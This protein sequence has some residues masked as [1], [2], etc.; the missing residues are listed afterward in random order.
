[1]RML[2]RH[3]CSHKSES[4]RKKTLKIIPQKTPFTR[5]IE[6][7]YFQCALR[8]VSIF[9]RIYKKRWQFNDEG[10][11]RENGALLDCWVRVKGNWNLLLWSHLCRFTDFLFTRRKQL[12]RNGIWVLDSSVCQAFHYP[13]SPPPSTHLKFSHCGDILNWPSERRL[14]SFVDEIRL[15]YMVK[16][17]TPDVPNKLPN[18]TQLGSMSGFC[19]RQSLSL[20]LFLYI[21]VIYGGF[22]LK[23]LESSSALN[24]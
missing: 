22:I 18:K 7:T 19:R 15:L 13:P 12:W 24:F 3:L 5:I 16:D 8:I 1:M 23:R 6:V 20:T 11:P 10:W 14:L 2:V 21:Y 17:T 4:N 9:G